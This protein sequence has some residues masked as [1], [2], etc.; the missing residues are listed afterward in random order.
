[1]RNMGKPPVLSSGAKYEQLVFEPEKAQMMQVRKF[2]VADVARLLGLY[3]WQ[4]GD[5]DHASQGG[6]KG[7][8]EQNRT[9]VT[10][11]LDG[12]LIAAEQAVSDDLLVR[13]LTRRYMRFNRD[14][15]LRGTTLQRYQALRLADFMTVNEKRALEGLPRVDGGDVLAVPTNTEPL[16][17]WL[18]S[19]TETPAEPAQAQADE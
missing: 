6:G 18:M 12:H 13:E 11:T 5:M 7:L 9:L 4:L 15:V 8:E 3:P 19:D 17:E 2:S 10:F 14:S 1:M 16:D